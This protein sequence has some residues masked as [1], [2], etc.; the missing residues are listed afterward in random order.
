MN[1]FYVLRSAK[2]D[3]YYYGSS[4]DLKRR[5]KQH[6]QG[7]VAATSFRLPLELVYYEAYNSIGKARSR[8]RQVKRS[9][10]IRNSLAKR[11]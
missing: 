1:Y 6:N 2:D 4:T 5:I 7:K 9:G 3:Q 8:E 11:I 10:S